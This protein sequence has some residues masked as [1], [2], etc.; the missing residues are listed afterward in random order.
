MRNAGEI[1]YELSIMF[2]AESPEKA[3][4]RLRAIADEMERGDRCGQSWVLTRET[5]D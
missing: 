2:D 3:V 5:E 1:Y 4:A